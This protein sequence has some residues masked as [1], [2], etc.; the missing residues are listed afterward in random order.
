[1]E[2]VKLKDLVDDIFTVKEVKGYTFK[3][4]NPKDNRFETSDKWQEGFAKKYQVETDKGMIDFGTGQLGTLLETVFHKGK[5]DIVG[6]TFG[7]TSN[8][9]TG[10][11]IRYYFKPT[12]AP[13]EL[14]KS[15][16]EAW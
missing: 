6:R 1:M 3:R 4:W 7:V 13:S 15:S 9:K 14:P 11:E 5:A 16:P 10:M 8:G 2:Y 12:S